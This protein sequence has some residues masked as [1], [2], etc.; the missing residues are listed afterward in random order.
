VQTC[1]LPIY[2]FREGQQR[3]D[4]RHLRLHGVWAPGSSISAGGVSQPYILY[5][6]PLPFESYGAEPGSRSARTVTVLEVG[7]DS[8]LVQETLGKEHSHYSA[9]PIAVTPASPPPAGQ[10]KP[11]IEEWAQAIV[12]AAPGWP[13]DPAVDILRRTPP[14]TRSGELAPARG[15]QLQPAVVAS[16]LDL[17]DSYLAVQGPPGTGKTYLGARVIAELITRHRW[18]VGVVAQS[19]AVVENLLCEI[20]KSGLPRHLVGKMV[21]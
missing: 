16:A 13:V 12:D 21:A 5:D 18:K 15:E 11:A 14:R 9:L 8:I 6:Q 19:H 1:A 17:D 3:V 4:R 2:W 7:D 10:Q 20:V